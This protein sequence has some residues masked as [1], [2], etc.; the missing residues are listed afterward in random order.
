MKGT[1][2]PDPVAAQS[3]ITNNTQSSSTT[4]NI[5]GGVGFT[6]D[7]LTALFDSDAVI[8]NRDSAQGRALR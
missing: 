6:T 3:N 7:D 8:I 1:S 5:S 4:I 2:M